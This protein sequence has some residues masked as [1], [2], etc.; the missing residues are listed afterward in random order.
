MNTYGEMNWLF[1]LMGIATILF[2]LPS[3][4]PLLM[5]YLTFH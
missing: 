4:V 5:L 3:G 2:F 1:I